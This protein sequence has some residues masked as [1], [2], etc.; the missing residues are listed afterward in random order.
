MSAFTR[1]RLNFT[2]Q[3]NFVMCHERTH[4]PQPPRM[5][6]RSG[7]NGIAAQACSQCWCAPTRF[8]TFL[9]QPP[10]NQPWLSREIQA[11]DCSRQPTLIPSANRGRARSSANARRRVLAE[12]AGAY[13]QRVGASWVLVIGRGAQSAR[14]PAGG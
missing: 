4:A 12:C 2:L 3:Q 10:P 11:L 14:W 13:L 9:P 8:A 1:L 7:S 5:S 6:Q